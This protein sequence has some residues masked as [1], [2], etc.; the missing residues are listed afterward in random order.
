MAPGKK[1]IISFFSF[2]LFCSWIA[3]AR[4][5]IGVEIELDR[6]NASIS[7][8]VT[9]RVSVFGA[10]GASTPRIQGT[11]AFRMTR[12]GTSTRMEI[13]NGVMSAGV[14]Y[15]Y[16]LQPLKKGSYVIG[17]ATV[18]AGGRTYSSNQVT[19]RVSEEPAQEA[20]PSN[21]VFLKA[22]LP[23]KDVYQEE[24]AVLT[25]KL[26]YNVQISNLS[27]DKLEAPGIE[28]A[29]IGKGAEYQ[30]IISGRPFQVVEVRY[31]LSAT[32]PGIYAI[33]PAIMQMSVYQERRRSGLFGDFFLGLTPSRPLTVSSNG[34]ELTVRELP[35]EGRPADFSGLVGS[36]RFETSLDPTEVTAGDS[37][38][39]TAV[40]SGTGNVRRIPE[41]RL[42]EP[43][44]VKTYAD[45]PSLDIRPENDGY[46]GRKTMKWALVPKNAGTHT[47]PPISVSYFDPADGTYKR[48]SGNPLVLRAKPGNAAAQPEGWLSPAASERE[49][50]SQK[51]EVELLGED[52]LPIHRSVAG[53][54]PPGMNPILLWTVF[55][56]P[57]LVFAGAVAS[58]TLLRRNRSK[59][60]VLLARK[61]AGGFI[62]HCNSEGCDAASLLNA[63]RRFLSE[64]LT[65]PG[66]YF[67]PA[68]CEALLIREGLDEKVAEHVRNLMEQLE[69]T[70]F[71]PGSREARSRLKQEWIHAVK[72][73]DKGLK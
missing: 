9:L 6:T 11:E 2:V 34:L 26:F 35:S 23:K 53:L 14:D 8:P 30:S 48:L 70:V 68:E 60:H 49:A 28:F 29:Q 73:V 22:S 19:L 72:K 7:D 51:K 1:V 71:S 56:F 32:K 33:P 62:G 59:A 55:L 52:I 17:P 43:E 64:R 16:Q 66:G 61:A 27:L 10:Q 69:H 37:A 20:S 31:L 41:L 5:E 67:G 45:Q 57:P 46:F 36:F 40:L 3:V 50:G 4:A 25:L 12:G 39:F 15:T 18:E 63:W 58:R 21:P 44:G 13:V 38:T 65:L 47:I 54:N 42:Q 24:A